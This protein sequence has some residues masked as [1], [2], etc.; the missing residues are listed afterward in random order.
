MHECHAPP[1][2]QK[3]GECRRAPRCT[4]PGDAAGTAGE[5]GGYRMRQQKHVGTCV[6]RGGSSHNAQTACARSVQRRRQ[7]CATRL[8]VAA[9]PCRPCAAACGARGIPQPLYSYQ[10]AP[11]PR[12]HLRLAAGGLVVAGGD[13]AHALGSDGPRQVHLEQ[14]GGGSVSCPSRCGGEVPW[15]PQLRGA[16]AGNGNRPDGTTCPRRLHS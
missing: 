2:P 14:G 7:A 16:R 10:L 4:G 8:R 9:A 5:P 13:G 15:P 11:T 1:L 3:S 12:W 6:M